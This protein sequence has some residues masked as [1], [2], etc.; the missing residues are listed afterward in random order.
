MLLTALIRTVIEAQEALAR[1]G[2]VEGSRDTGIQYTVES[3]MEIWVGAVAVGILC[4]G[5]VDS[6]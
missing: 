5:M 6:N 3:E 1:P 2:S 4:T